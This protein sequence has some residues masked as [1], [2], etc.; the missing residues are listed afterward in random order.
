MKSKYDVF[1]GYRREDGSELANLVSSELSKRGFRVFIDVRDLDAGHFD[2]K[3][4]ELIETTPNFIL[5]LKPNSLFRVNRENDWLA[6]EISH[7]IKTKRNIVPLILHHAVTYDSYYVDASIKRLCKLLKKRNTTLKKLFL[8]TIILLLSL[9]TFI[10][11]WRIIGQHINR[12]VVTRVHSDLV[13]DNDKHLFRIGLLLGVQIARLQHTPPGMTRSMSNEELSLFQHSLSFLKFP[14]EENLMNVLSNFMKL[15]E[16]QNHGVTYDSIFKAVKLLGEFTLDKYGR[17]GRAYYEIGLVIPQVSAFI[18]Y[19]NFIDVAA[20]QSQSKSPQIDSYK[21]FY[22][23]KNLAE[24][25]GTVLNSW[26]RGTTLPTNIVSWANAV[27]NGDIRDSSRRM[28][29][30]DAANMLEMT[31]GTSMQK[32]LPWLPVVVIEH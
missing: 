12:S 22:Y 13:T 7:A 29:M 8:L 17:D 26:L 4:L 21:K 25:Y 16:Q 10:I 3:L 27:T 24:V 14:F 28:S 23:E 6:K 1:I 30:R 5:I 9:S 15:L 18:W 2:T 32:D 31:L 20:S 19:Y 11:A